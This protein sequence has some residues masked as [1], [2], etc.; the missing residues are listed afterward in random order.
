ML[1]NGYGYSRKDFNSSNGCPYVCMYHVSD[2]KCPQWLFLVVE[3]DFQRRP[4]VKTF[5]AQ[6]NSHLG[7][8]NVAEGGVVCSQLH[9]A[10]GRG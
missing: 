1:T 9:N 7:K 10:G 3:D 8:K 4:P 2:G 5:L 6:L